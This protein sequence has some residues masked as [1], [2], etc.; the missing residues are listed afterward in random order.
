MRKQPRDAEPGPGASAQK[1]HWLLGGLPLLLLCPLL[2]LGQGTSFL[3][4]GFEGRDLFWNPGPSDAPNKQLLHALTDETRHGGH[5]SECFE[6]QVQQ[7]TFLSYTHDV[8]R[9]LVSEEL[10]ASL[11]VKANR[12]GTQ[13]LARVVLPH[14]RNPKNLAQPL[15]TLVR[16]DVYQTAGRWQPLELRQPL[17]SSNNSSNCSAPN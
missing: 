4:H 13:L 14:E 11:W 2:L 6:L 7:G 15:T 9:G 5:Q 16:G 8:G 10:S 12:P 1:W 17:R 3:Q